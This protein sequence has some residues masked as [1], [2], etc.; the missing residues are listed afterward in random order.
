M[1]ADLLSYFSTVYDSSVHKEKV[2]HPNIDNLDGG[3]NN[4]NQEI[5]A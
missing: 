3:G 5:K 2:K 1:W 4:E